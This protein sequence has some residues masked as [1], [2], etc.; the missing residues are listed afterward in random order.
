M[1][2]C[3]FFS[4]A[5]QL[6]QPKFFGYMYLCGASLATVMNYLQIHKWFTSTVLTCKLL[7]CQLSSQ[8]IPPIDLHMICKKS[9]LK[10]KLDELD[11]SSI[12]NLNFAGYTDTKIQ[13]QK[14]SF[15]TWCLKKCSADQYEVHSSHLL[16]QIAGTPLIDSRIDRRDHS[17]THWMHIW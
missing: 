7:Q 5:S 15:P 2:F 17:Y 14:S 1:L 16:Y 12:S 3:R 10:I 6:A 4:A 8:L 13:V 9:S 11:F